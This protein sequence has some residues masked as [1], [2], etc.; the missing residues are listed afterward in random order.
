MKEILVARKAISI[1]ALAVLSACGGG[2]SGVP[3]PKVSMPNPTPA[4]TSTPPAPTTQDVATQF[5]I[6]APSATTA[7]R[8]RPQYVTANVKSVVITLDTVNGGAP[9]TGLV[10]AVTDNVTITSCPC[11]VAG[12][13][14][15]PGIDTFTL[16]TYD[17]T[18]ATGNAISTA[19][20]TL[21]IAAVAANNN[22]ITLDGI[23]KTFSITGL[24]SG[25]AGT[26]FVSPQAFTVA[27]KDADGNTITGSYASAVTIADNDSSSLTLGTALAVNNGSAASSVNSTA[28]TDTFTL[29]YG[30]LAI[31]PAAITASAS[32]A[33]S[34]TAA[35]TPTLASIV[36]SGPAVSSLPEVDLYA[37]SGTGSSGSFSATE[38]GW[39]NAPYNKTFTTSVPSACSTIAGVSP[40]S[41]TSFTATAAASP[42]AGMCTMSFG[43]GAGQSQ[44][45]KLTYT[46]M[47]FG[48]Q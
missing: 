2:A 30:G 28:S 14:V 48:A 7:A 32:G 12:P 45:I 21:T 39:T 42:S 1:A 13:S 6:S 8:V 38:T 3:G 17:N 15:P 16:T 34:A 24:P 25:T 4:A 9:P 41:G 22:V 19:S 18:N 20:P 37:T 26:A 47:S 46:T 5:T 11:S 44:N 40:S 23:P 33:T 29:N 35:F 43:D 31:V 27:V 10:T 36:Y